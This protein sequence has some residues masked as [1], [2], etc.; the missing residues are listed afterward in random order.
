MA[1]PLFLF[2]AAST[3]CWIP[4]SLGNSSSLEMKKLRLAA[5]ADLALPPSRGLSGVR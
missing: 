5:L 2:L 1:G 4:Y 3:L